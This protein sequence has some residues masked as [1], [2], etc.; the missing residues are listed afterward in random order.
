MSLPFLTRSLKE[1]VGV[2]SFLDGEP[3]ANLDHLLRRDSSVPALWIAGPR[4]WEGATLE[5]LERIFARNP[6]LTVVEPVAANENLWGPWSWSHDAKTS[7]Q[8]EWRG[9]RSNPVLRDRMISLES[10]VRELGWSRVYDARLDLAYQMPWTRLFQEQAAHWI[11]RFYELRQKGPKKVLAVDFDNTLWPGQISE[12]DPVLEP[13]TLEGDAFR[14]FQSV[15]LEIKR[16]GV[17]LVGCTR[18][19]PSTVSEKF[20]KIPG[21]KLRLSDFA[22]VYASWGRK[23]D[24]LQ[25]ASREFGF[26]LDQMCFVDDDAAEVHRM[27][28]DL[29]TVSCLQLLK[30]P[31]LRPTQILESCWFWTFHQTTEDRERTHQYQSA[32]RTRTENPQELTDLK[33]EVVLEKARKQDLDRVHQLVGKTNQFN[34]TTERWTLSEVFDRYNQGGS[35]IWV[36]RV[37]DQFDD[38]G[39]V[40]AL[41]LKRDLHKTRIENWVMSCR[42]FSRQVEQRVWQKMTSLISGPI[43]TV[44]VPS[45]RNQF[46]LDRLLELGFIATETSERGASSLTFNSEEDRGSHTDLLAHANRL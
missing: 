11:L 1:S 18:N 9:L 36:Y 40:G 25:Q 26:S 20:D 19:D 2:V 3:G 23:S 27:Q 10:L 38:L 43:E 22:R 14:R 32:L 42:A 35:E 17:L 8:E 44:W 46:A 6:Q 12:D 24:H 5:T 30:D 7:L 45:G 4:D 28:Q 15:L 16:G 37:R 41:F 39:L 29:P 33:V 34:L 13:G 21:M 31:A